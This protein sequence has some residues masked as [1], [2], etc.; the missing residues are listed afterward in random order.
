L[1]LLFSIAKLNW[2]PSHLVELKSFS[3][4]IAIIERR[5]FGEKR[6][7]DAFYLVCIWSDSWWNK[8]FNLIGMA[9]I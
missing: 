8:S 9:L 2:V 4:S 5:F 7:L 1:I 3:F 6:T